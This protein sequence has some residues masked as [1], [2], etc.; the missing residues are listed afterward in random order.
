M[1]RFCAIERP[2]GNA[3]VCGLWCTRKGRPSGRR[4]QQQRGFA[5]L[6]IPFFEESKAAMQGGER[7]AGGWRWPRGIEGV[8][9]IEGAGAGRIEC[10]AGGG[11][12]GADIGILASEERT[13]ER[14]R[15][16]GPAGGEGEDRLAQRRLT[17]GKQIGGEIRAGWAWGG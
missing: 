11:G 12:G 15:G 8:E 16:G 10:G 9:F 17:T 2:V 3:D 4:G 5:E 6:G 14:G 7:F 13:G 1:R